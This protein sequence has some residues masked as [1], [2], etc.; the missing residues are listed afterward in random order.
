MNRFF[1]LFGGP[2]AV[3]LSILS[4]VI[5]SRRWKIYRSKNARRVPV[6][7]LYWGPLF[8]MACMFLHIVQNAYR[9]IVSFSETGAFNFYFYSLQLFGFV[10][11]YQCYLLL[12]ACR[13]HAGGEKR[14][15]SPLLLNIG[16]IVLTTLPTFMFTPIGIIPSG[17][18]AITF[19]LSISIHRSAK[20]AKFPVSHYETVNELQPKEL[21]AYV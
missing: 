18:L 11:G 3:L 17:V 1:E 20:K 12:K 9:A 4:T 6:A 19:L 2:I 13:K 10:V 14:V 5:V 8:L 21:T 16:L 15:S 7:F